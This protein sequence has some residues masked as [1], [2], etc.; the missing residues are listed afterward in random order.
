MDIR[1]FTVSGAPCPWRV[2][3]GMAIKNIHY[4]TELLSR[5]DNEHKTE[6]YLRL[7][8]RGTVPTLVSKDIVLRDSIAILAWLDRVFLE[9]PLFGET[10]EEAAEIWQ[11]T[12][13]LVDYL[14]IAA[15]TV[16]SPLFF[17]NANK[18]TPELLK[19]SGTLR[20]ELQV[21]DR[22]L[23]RGDFLAGGK[24]TAA[25]A[26]AFPHVRLVQ[27]AMETKSDMMTA[28]GLSNFGAFTQKLSKWVNRIE[29]LPGVE[30]TFPPHWGMQLEQKRDV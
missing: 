20:A 24:P 25:D 11:K 2:T 29:D 9:N 26:V 4:N 30:K 10:P 15:S 1:L 28:L 7:N 6:S 17:K 14:P 12:M 23:Q 8:P 18:V 19:A 21:L 27:R 13:E 3:I 22:L 5:S 16:L